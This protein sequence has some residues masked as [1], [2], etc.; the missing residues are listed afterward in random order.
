MKKT[1]KFICET[2]KIAQI[3]AKDINPMTA[4][5]IDNEADFIDTDKVSADKIISVDALMEAVSDMQNNIKLAKAKVL[6]TEQTELVESE[7]KAILK[8]AK[9]F[10]YIMLID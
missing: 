6:S 8:E 7:V 2:L 3:S 5:L 4:R 10:Q 1:K 9:S